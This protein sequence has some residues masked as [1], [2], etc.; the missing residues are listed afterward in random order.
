MI[1]IFTLLFLL[2]LFR[3]FFP[4]YKHIVQLRFPVYNFKEYTP[5]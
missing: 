1:F 4:Y 3:H 5:Y 2:L